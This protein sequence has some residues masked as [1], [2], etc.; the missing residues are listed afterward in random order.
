M[1]S[2]ILL[3]PLADIV[4]LGHSTHSVFSLFTYVFEVHRLQDDDLKIGV[5][6]PCGHILHKVDPVCEVYFPGTQCLQTL[7]FVDATV[8]EYVPISHSVHCVSSSYENEP[9]EQMLHSP[10]AL[11]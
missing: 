10:P 11:P 4:L 1:H 3:L 5:N 9:N 8:V 6:W 7:E 2:E